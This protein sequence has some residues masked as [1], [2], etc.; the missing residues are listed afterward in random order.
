MFSGKFP[1]VQAFNI[2]MTIIVSD[3]SL[4]AC[5]V[6]PD[7]SDAVVQVTGVFITAGRILMKQDKR[8]SKKDYR[9]NESHFNEIRLYSFERDWNR[10]SSH[11]TNSQQKVNPNR[12]CQSSKKCRYSDR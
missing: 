1:P 7:P 6:L 9:I 12:N 8:T 4:N 3:N 11:K 2:D 10:R 5:F